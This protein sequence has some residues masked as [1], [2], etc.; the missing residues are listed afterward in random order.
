MPT[1]K[2]PHI[3]TH[4]RECRNVFHSTLLHALQTMWENRK[5]RAFQQY[6]WEN[7]KN[8]IFLRTA[9]TV[10]RSLNMHSHCR[11]NTWEN[12]QFMYRSRHITDA[13]TSIHYNVLAYHPSAGH[14]HALTI[15]DMMIICCW[16]KS[17]LIHDLQPF[18]DVFTVMSLK[19]LKEWSGC[20][21]T[22]YSGEVATLFCYIQLT[23]SRCNVLEVISV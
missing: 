16:V 10:I 23:R 4:V 20:T 1:A 22:I 13:I 19:P 7:V 14:S 8:L 21:A 12:W 11:K 2:F 17:M 3:Y 9:P 18:S 15:C 5:P 6:V